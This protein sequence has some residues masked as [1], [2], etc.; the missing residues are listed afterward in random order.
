MATQTH[1]DIIEYYHNQGWKKHKMKKHLRKR[2][3][4][5]PWCNDESVFVEDIIERI[6]ECGFLPDCWRCVIERWNWHVLVLECLEVCVT[7]RLTETKLIN[8]SNLWMDFD[9]SDRL[10]LRLFRVNSDYTM[11]T[12]MNNAPLYVGGHKLSEAEYKPIFTEIPKEIN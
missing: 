1:K 9:A 4:Q 7:H 8:Y 5:K 12:V 2:L 10:H 3:L 11:S 6:N